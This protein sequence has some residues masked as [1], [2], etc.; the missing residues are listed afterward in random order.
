MVMADKRLC[1][2]HCILRENCVA[3]KYSEG[4]QMCYLDRSL[5]DEN[6]FDRDPT[7]IFVRTDKMGKNNSSIIY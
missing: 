1:F 4:C 7:D 3:V 6:V 5:N 2:N